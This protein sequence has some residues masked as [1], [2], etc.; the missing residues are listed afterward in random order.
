M[1]RRRKS[2]STRRNILLFIL[3]ILAAFLISY[4]NKKV[5]EINMKD[6]KPSYYYPHDLERDEYLR[7]QGEEVE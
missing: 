3:V 1:A 6:K 7:E 4:I 5:D 2:K